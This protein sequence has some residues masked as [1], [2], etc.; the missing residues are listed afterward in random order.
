[1]TIVV[2]P[3]AM[4]VMHARLSDTPQPHLSRNR[5]SPDLFVV[6]CGCFVNS[7]AKVATCLHGGPE[8]VLASESG[9]PCQDFSPDGLNKGAWSVLPEDLLPHRCCCVGVAVF[10]HVLRYDF[11]VATCW[12]SWQELVHLWQND[13]PA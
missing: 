3:P 5:V 10:S 6:S 7:S 2:G 8:H 12:K 11:T 9:F 1:M 13:R 4:H